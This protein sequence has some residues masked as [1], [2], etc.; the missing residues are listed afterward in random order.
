MLH[1]AT[2]REVV[3]LGEIKS[4]AQPIQKSPIKHTSLFVKEA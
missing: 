1:N 2:S 4:L 3:T